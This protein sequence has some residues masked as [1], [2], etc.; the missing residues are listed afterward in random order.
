MILYK[1][2]KHSDFHLS[3]F[4]I[5]GAWWVFTVVT[6]LIKYLRVYMV[7]G[8]AVSKLETSQE[9]PSS[10]YVVYATSACVYNYRKITDNT[11]TLYSWFDW[12]G[13]AIHHEAVGVV[14]IWYCV[15]VGPC[16]HFLTEVFAI[17]VHC[18]VC[19]AGFI[20]RAEVFTMNS[21]VVVFKNIFHTNLIIFAGLK[22]LITGFRTNWHIWKTKGKNDALE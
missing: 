13:W 17:A 19:Y 20:C 8:D 4:Q 15:L 9:S 11:F 14:S 2:G 18:L 21:E 16:P 12:F 6:K 7:L 3:F 22:P 1:M 5:V 10:K